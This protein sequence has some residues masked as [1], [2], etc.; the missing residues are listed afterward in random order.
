MKPLPITVIILLLILGVQ[1]AT[2]ADQ[3]A[4]PVIDGDITDLANGSSSLQ[5][6]VPAELCTFGLE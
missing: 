3:P 6:N 2:A 4:P 1:V 5:S